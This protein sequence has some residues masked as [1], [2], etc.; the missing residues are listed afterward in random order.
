VKGPKTLQVLAGI[1]VHGTGLLTDPKARVAKLVL[2]FLID[3][4]G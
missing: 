1:S 3:H 2:D 4:R